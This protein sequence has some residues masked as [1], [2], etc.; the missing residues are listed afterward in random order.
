MKPL[1]QTSKLHWIFTLHSVCVILTRSLQQ[2]SRLQ[3]SEQCLINKGVQG[4]GGGF[5]PA[6][7][8]QCFDQTELCRLMQVTEFNL[9]SV[10]TVTKSN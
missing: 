1:S 8:F 10:L 6:T 7:I 4:G 5:E 9:I 3:T 2:K